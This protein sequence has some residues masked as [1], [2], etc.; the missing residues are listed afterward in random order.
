LSED[1]R[2]KNKE[3]NTDGKRKGGRKRARE[4]TNIIIICNLA[5]AEVLKRKNENPQYKL[6]ALS[7]PQAIMNNKILDTLS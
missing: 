7:A 6:R 1:Y 5:C 4:Q 2:G 3:S